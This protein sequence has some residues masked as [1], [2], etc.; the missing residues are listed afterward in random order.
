M[1]RLAKER[2][3]QILAFFCDQYLVLFFILTTTVKLTIINTYILHVTWPFNQYFYGIVIGFLVV[4][5][6][7]SPLYFVGKHKNK[8]ASI[9]ATLLTVLLLIDTV[10]FLYFSALPSVGLLSSLGQVGDV[11]PAVGTLLQWW[12]LAYFADIAFVIAFNKL[13]KRLIGALKSKNHY[14]KT[15][16]KTSLAFTVIS[17]AI[18]M[19]AISSLGFN[20]LSDML[21]ESYDTVSTAQYYGL[22]MAH[23]IDITRFIKEET[24][25]LSA[26]E[27]QAISNW[28]KN[29]PNQATSD[30]NGVAK[31]KNI[32]VLQVE[33]LGGFVINQKINNQEITPNLNKLSQASQFFPNNRFII[34]AGHTSDTDFVANT[35]FFPLGD[36]SVFVRYGNDDFSSL[37]KALISEGYSAYAFHGYNRNFWNRSVALESLGYQKFYA[38]DNYPKGT[39]INMGLND[40]DF[41]DKTVDYIKDQ[42]KPSFSYVITL[43][44]HTPFNITSE[45]KGLD[46]VDSNSYPNGVGGYLQNINYTDRM[47]GNF[48]DQLKSEGLYEDSLILVYG[49]HTPVLPSFNA[50]TIKYS[51]SSVQTKEVPLMIKLPNES[52]GKTYENTGTNLDIMPT[53]LDLTSTKTNQVMFGQSLFIVGDDALK[54]CTD[55]LV[56]LTDKNCEAVLN[57]EKDNSAKIIRYN[58]F[59]ILPK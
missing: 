46:N 19:I 1:V 3:R 49:D 16:K 27:K 55:Q 31:G 48:F 39:L 17:F 13:I 43:T 30:L 34:G 18:L 14:R 35:S 4:A 20:K 41:L 42:P 21:D 12:M 23:G 5:V 52:S 59:D 25:S 28:I 9:L 53:I 32:I 57:D 38:A 37:P 51:S 36:A 58:L 56:A 8:W 7:F 50:G 45:T 44:S 15:G 26:S 22:L 47:I 40:G 33:S 11:G 24:V 54:V 6:I 2:L 10:Y 29:N